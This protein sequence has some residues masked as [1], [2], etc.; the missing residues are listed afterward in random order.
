[1][2]LSR[3]W[4][5]APLLALVLAPAAAHGAGAHTAKVT[6]HRP[7]AAQLRAL[8]AAMARAGFPVS[9]WIPGDPALSSH[10]GGYAIATPIAR[11]PRD[12]GNGV[13]I[14]VRSDGHW[15]VLTQG[16]SFEG[17][18]AGI[19]KGVLKA[20]LAVPGEGTIPT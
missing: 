7:S 12:Q 20:L 9:K 6:T 14:F 2:R 19:P 10:P 15:R 13:V 4:L 3:A 17:P 16:S 11:N 18:V 5:L 1:M 8:A